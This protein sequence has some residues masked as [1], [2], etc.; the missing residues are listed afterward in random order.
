MTQQTSVDVAADARLQG[1]FARQ[2]YPLLFV[3]ISR[4]HLY[5][6]PSPDSDFDLRGCHVLP[7]E[8]AVGLD[9]GRET[10]ESTRDEAGVEV[11]FVS[12]DALKFFGLLLKKNGYVLEQVYSPLVVHSTPEHEELQAIARG[13]VTRHHNRYYRGSPSPSGAC[14]RGPDRRRSSRSSIS[15]ES[16]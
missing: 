13:C 9:P 8:E 5:G 12:H 1:V 10:I 16:C 11:D 4:A 14:S 2:P 3:T 15:T 6:F 7:V